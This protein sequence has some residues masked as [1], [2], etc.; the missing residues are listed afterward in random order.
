MKQQIPFSIFL[1]IERNEE[2]K[3]IGILLETCK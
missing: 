3:K 1:T 2:D